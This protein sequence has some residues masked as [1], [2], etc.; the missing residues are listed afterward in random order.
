MKGYWRIFVLVFF[1]ALLALIYRWYYYNAITLAHIQMQALVLQNYVY[2]NY[3]QSV[4]LYSALFILCTLLSI[5]VTLLLTITSGFLFGTI[6]GAFYSTMSAMLGALLL[7]SFSRYVVGDWIQ[8]RYGYQ[9]HFFN[10]EI[11][12]YGAWYIFIL[13]LFPM[14]PIFLINVAAGISVISI[15]NFVWSTLLGML[16]ATLIYTWAGTNLYNIHSVNEMVTLL[17]AVLA[18]VTVLFFV[19]FLIRRYFKV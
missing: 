10:N 6:G 15:R 19:A 3:M 7:F 11:R 12:S 14:S 18:L 4:L 2:H 9:L 16:P 5:P 17:M 1:G 8:K 13:Q